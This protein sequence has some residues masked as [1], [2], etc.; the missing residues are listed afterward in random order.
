[1]THSQSQLALDTIKSIPRDAEGPVFEA[2]WQAEIFAITLTLHQQQLFTWSE[3]ADQLSRSIKQ[4]QE[5]GDQD[6]GDTYY[7]H[8]LDAL[9][10]IIVAKGIGNAGQLTQLY[11]QWETAAANT[12]HGQT[13]VLPTEAG[14][15]S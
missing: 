6:L 4:A 7:L 12:P 13:I 1:M 10:N 15:T 3:W 2:P 9:E 8:W 11:T 14:E 5:S